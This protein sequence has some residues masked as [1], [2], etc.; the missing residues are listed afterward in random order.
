MK[1]LALFALLCASLRAGGS[2]AI[3]EQA[4]PASPAEQQRLAAL[5]RP[6]LDEPEAGG[7]D[8]A[9]PEGDALEMFL[10]GAG[11]VTVAAWAGRKRPA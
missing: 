10:L 7:K 1:R 8:A 2:E 4:F 11:L 9:A 5:A 6:G 3:L